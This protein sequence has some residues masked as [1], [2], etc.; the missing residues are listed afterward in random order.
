MTYTFKKGTD[1]QRDANKR[2]LELRS[3][4]LFEFPVEEG[5]KRVFIPMLENCQL[6][7]GQS[8]NLGEYSLIG[9]NNNLYSYTS[10]KSREFKLSFFITLPH[11]QHY[12]SEEGLDSIFKKNYVEGRQ[13]ARNQFYSP[14]RGVGGVEHGRINKDYYFSKSGAAPTQ[15]SRTRSLFGIFPIGSRGTD[16]S[17]NKIIDL[18]MFWINIVRSSV[19][20]NS[21]QTQFGPPIVRLTHGVMYQNVPCVCK[22]YNISF[23]EN[24]STFDIQTLLNRRIKIDLNLSETR[25]GNFG[26]FVTFD[27]VKGD[28]NTG[29]EAVFTQNNMDPFNGLIQ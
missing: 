28:N 12:L 16:T 15:S 11:V 1:Q 29:W 3:H 17:D 5:V 19:K 4:L 21:E 26:K 8:S 23:D 20:N 18:I 2:V 9:R 10:G 25:V 13:Q 27:G 7:E 14:L 6:S 22:S 24:N